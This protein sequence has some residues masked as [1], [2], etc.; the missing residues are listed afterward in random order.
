[1]IYYFD[2]LIILILSIGILLEAENLNVEA[3]IHFI[4]ELT[5]FRDRQIKMALIAEKNNSG[6]IEIILK[7]IK[8]S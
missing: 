3:E 5:K 4:N 1:M 8:H 2:E 7:P 6:I